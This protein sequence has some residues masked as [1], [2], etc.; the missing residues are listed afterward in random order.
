MAGEIIVKEPDEVGEKHFP[1]LVFSRDAE[2]LASNS[3]IRDYKNLT[4]HYSY[5]KPGPDGATYDYSHISVKRFRQIWFDSPTYP[6]TA[7]RN[8]PT[9]LALQ[10]LDQ[11]NGLCRV[12]Q[13]THPRWE[14]HLDQMIGTAK[15]MRAAG[16]KAA[17]YDNWSFD[18]LGPW[19]VSLYNQRNDMFRLK[20]AL[21]GQNAKQPSKHVIADKLRPYMDSHTFKLYCAYDLGEYGSSKW[22][23]WVDVMEYNIAFAELLYPDMPRYAWIQPNYPSGGF[24]PMEPKVWE[25]TLDYLMS[26]SIDGIIIFALGSKDQPSGWKDY[27]KA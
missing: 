20:R 24:A 8:E 13:T 4:S 12:G 3:A 21:D 9:R 7:D 19:W 1:K 25:K 27:F 5:D 15:L 26:T 23:A 17:W 14:E 16:N 10:T 22:Q 18:F 2:I 6:Y 11:E